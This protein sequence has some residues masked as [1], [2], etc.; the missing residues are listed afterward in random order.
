MNTKGFTLIEVTIVVAILALIGSTSVFF[1]AAHLKQASLESQRR[2][3][4]TALQTARSNAMNN[5][6][7]SPHGVAIYP[8][9]IKGYV[10]FVGQNYS[11]RQVKH[12]TAFIETYPVTISTSSPAEIIFSQLSGDANY[13]G[14][15]ILNNTNQNS[16]TSVT[17]NHEG[18]I[19][20]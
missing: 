20:W 6:Q 8:S 5:I 4:V 1:T 9:G 19:G 16:S 3:L 15:V 13:E 18:K 14:K 2:L 12:D 17:I 11:G 7:E 10:L